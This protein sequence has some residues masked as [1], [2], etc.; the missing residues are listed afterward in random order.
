MAAI[1][2]SLF[3]GSDVPASGSHLFGDA[4]RRHTANEHGE[5][6]DKIAAQHRAADGNGV[7]GK[8]T[9]HADQEKS[10]KQKISDNHDAGEPLPE[11]K[12]NRK[13]AKASPKTKR[14][15]PKQDNADEVP[16]TTG[17]SMDERKATRPVKSGQDSEEKLERTV[18]VGNLPSD[19]K[20]KQISRLFA[21][22]GTVQSIRLRSVPVAEDSKLPR[23]AACIT[24]VLSQK[25]TNV[26][27][28]LV[29]ELTD[30]AKAAL[31]LNM[32]EFN[33]RHLRV[34][35]A[36][37]VKQPSGVSRA[38]VEYDKTRSVFIGNLPRDI[39]EDELIKLFNGKSSTIEAV[40]ELSNQV[41]AVRVV[42]DAHTN[43]GKGIAFILFKT[44]GAA[45]AAL[46][47]AGTKVKEREI[48]V[49]RVTASTALMKT[50]ASM[51][52]PMQGK[53]AAKFSKQHLP[54]TGKQQQGQHHRPQPFEGMRATKPGK[55]APK[56]ASSVRVQQKAGKGKDSSSSSVQKAKRPAVLAR[57]AAGKAARQAGITP[58]AFQQSTQKA[59]KG[60]KG[61]QSKAGVK[62]KRY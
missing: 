15:Q 28:Y 20:K 43:A 16:S 32:H 4:F 9:K 56:G 61:A 59:P 41:E 7:K 38:S 21:Q 58:A 30:E 44:K 26:N 37:P 2:D 18:F 5:K 10:K 14:K 33:G 12:L 48:R 49:T 13:L 51:K 17:L 57:K 53:Y 50:P 8:D 3:G 45:R 47:L 39:E 24:G 23:R 22:F 25:R 46:S 54:N 31:A 62:R 36:A 11:A 1:F 52:K 6:P 40:S 19:V 42:R 60:S 27:A 34:D 35:A 29:F 55:K